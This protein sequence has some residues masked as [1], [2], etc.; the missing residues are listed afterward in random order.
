MSWCRLAILTDEVSQ[1][2]T[3]V[4][5]FAREFQLDGIEV[6]SL[7][8]RAFKDLTTGDLKTI[9][10]GAR[11]TGLAIAG[12]ASP[13]FKC[14]LDSPS[15]IAAHVELFKRS[16]EAAHLLGTDLIRVFAF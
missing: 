16:V 15:V 1:E 5:R 11:E 7:F 8:G 3:D 10:A 14:D 13:V 12:C 4:L 6:R 2:L 9:A